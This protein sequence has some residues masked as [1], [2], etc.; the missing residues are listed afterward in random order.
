[1]LRYLIIRQVIVQLLP[2][3]VLSEYENPLDALA[4]MRLTPVDLAVMSLETNYV[5]GLDYIPIIVNEH[6]ARQTVVVCE[7]ND[8]R[9]L[10]AL[11]K[12]QVTVCLDSHTVSLH[13]LT[14]AVAAAIA[15]HHYISPSILEAWRRLPV[16]HTGML[17]S[18]REELVLS[19][20][21][22]GS[23]NS[24]AAD[25]L[26]V[27]P[28]TVRSHRAH[29]MHKL[30]L[31]HK[32]QLILY[33]HKRGYTRIS[34]R[35]LIHPG[36]HGA[37]QGLVS[38]RG[39]RLQ[40]ATAAADGTNLDPSALQLLASAALPV[41]GVAGRQEVRPHGISTRKP[42]DVRQTEGKTAPRKHAGQWRTF[43][44][45]N[46]VGRLTLWRSN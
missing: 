41:A 6:L 15:G 45:Q 29:I 2:L 25:Y 33:A 30:N 32:G 12:S 7:R 28:E 21:G 3:A 16:P 37:L 11:R 22:R 19:I 5:D 1:M 42:A 23:D 24:E 40:G 17:L 10:V 20:L 8:E 44:Q 9:T 27:S 36:F 39:V 43:S 46:N 31:H 13:E 34:S 18:S 4:A 26:A 14:L 38:S 35:G